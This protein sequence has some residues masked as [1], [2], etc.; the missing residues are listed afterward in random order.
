VISGGDASAGTVGTGGNA[1][2]DQFP[3][4]TTADGIATFLATERYKSWAHK[5]APYPAGD[6]QFHGDLML[7]YFNEVAL[8]THEDAAMHAMTVKEL[9]D[10]S[11]NQIG[12]AAA[13]KTTEE[14]DRWT[15]YCTEDPPGTSC[16]NN[17]PATFPIYEVEQFFQGCALCHADA[18]ISS[19]P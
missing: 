5:P 3:A 18:I 14:D 13:L 1:T 19:P 10:A 11:G 12:I 15:Y 7:A 9:Y 4:D 8:A 2:G 16:T 6:L 17:P